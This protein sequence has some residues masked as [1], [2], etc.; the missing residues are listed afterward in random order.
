VTSSGNDKSALESVWR[1]FYFVGLIFVLMLFVY[2]F[3]VLEEGEGYNAVLAR[4]YRREAKYG[5]IEAKNLH[6][7]SI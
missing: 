1:S 5:K 7:K 2:R 4:R 3:L 6:K